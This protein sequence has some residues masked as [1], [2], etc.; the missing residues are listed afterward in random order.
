[1]TDLENAFNFDHIPNGTHNGRVALV[2][3][4]NIGLGYWTAYHLAMKGATVVLACRNQQKCTEAAD[5]IQRAVV[6]HNLKGS[7][8]PMVVDLSSLASVQSFTEAFKERFDRLDIFVQNAGIF[9]SSKMSYSVDGI[10]I[11]FATNHLGHFKMT[12]DLRNLI[13]RTAETGMATIT[14]VSSV[15][16]Y[17]ISEPTQLH[18]DLQQLNDPKNF[19]FSYYALTKVSNVFF[20]QELA[21]RLRSKNI[22]VNVCHPGVVFTNLIPSTIARESLGFGLSLLSNL[23]TKIAPLVMWSAEDGAR[24]QFFL[25][26]DWSTLKDKN[27]TG[28]YFHPVGLQVEPSTIS[29]N[30]T[31]QRALWEFSERILL[32]KHFS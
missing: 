3:G 9:V 28:R 13:V 18:F 10:E 23:L 25:A 7:A 12:K 27:I 29:K 6:A 21:S 2:T 20:A 22:F 17:E 5:E 31:L 15:S 11:T 19:G 30:L 4:A 8:I 24:T 26:A 14:V 16:H 1:M 32:D